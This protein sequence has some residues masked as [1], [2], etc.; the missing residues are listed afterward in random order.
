[1]SELYTSS[2]CYLASFV[3]FLTVRT[4]MESFIFFTLFEQFSIRAKN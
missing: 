4:P 3:E 1:M 2:E